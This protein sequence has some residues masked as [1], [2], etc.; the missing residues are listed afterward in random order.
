[1]RGQG[2]FSL[3]LKSHN[4]AAVEALV[5]VEPALVKRIMNLPKMNLALWRQQNLN[6]APSDPKAVHTCRT[7]ALQYVFWHFV[8]NFH[9]SRHVALLE[10][11]RLL[12]KHDSLK[13]E[14]SIQCACKHCNHL[15][16]CVPI[17]VQLHQEGTAVLNEDS[18]IRALEIL[19]ATPKE[20][21]HKW[22]SFDFAETLFKN[23]RFRF[24]KVF[25]W[26]KQSKAL[27]PI[28]VE[29]VTRYVLSS[30]SSSSFG[31]SKR[32]CCAGRRF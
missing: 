20:T 28:R 9:P 32:G 11:L 1:M 12:A 10:L 29:S 26:L 22:N 14:A 30:V 8:C 21:G 31:L 17:E 27:N 19:W 2:D 18:L 7:T 15:D 4:V 13:L 5:L 23:M 16:A 6:E 24:H 25:L 3:A